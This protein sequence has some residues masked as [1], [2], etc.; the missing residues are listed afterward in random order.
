MKW[1]R[2]VAGS[3]IALALAVIGVV[4]FGG[5]ELRRLQTRVNE[6][7]LER[8]AL[9]QFAAELSAVRRV[10]QVEVLAQQ[11]DD[12]GRQV[13]RIQWQEL[14]EAGVLGPPKLLDVLGQVIY[15]EALVLK[16]EPRPAPTPT[17]APPAHEPETPPTASI[18]LFRRVFG[19]QQRPSDGPT[20]SPQQD[21]GAANERRQQLWSRFWELSRDAALAARLGVRFAHIE[22][23]GIQAH[24]GDI[25]EVSVSTVGGINL[26]KVG[27]R[28]Q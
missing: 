17:N 8:A 7:E 6:L 16:F 19:D 26:R 14:G 21:I 9:L 28:A 13:N 5:F 27:V 4:Q 1:L 10:A 23:P 22:A 15:F 20:L 3:A 25:W 11:R 2:F 24:V 18:A 12:A